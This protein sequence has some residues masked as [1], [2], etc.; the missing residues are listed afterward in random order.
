[1]KILHLDTGRTMRGGQWQAHYLM[2]G[3]RE[4]GHEVYFNAPHGVFDIVHAHDAKA[5]RNAVLRGLKPLVVSRRVAF[6]IQRGPFSR[7][8]Y[9]HGHFIAIS[10]FVKG[11]LLEAGIDES[12]IDV[13]HDGVPRLERAQPTDRVVVLDKRKPGSF[14][15]ERELP[16]ARAF[17]YL[18]E[19]E[20]LGSA[21][22]LAM[23]AGVPV[24]A[25]R[26]GGIPEAVE[27]G[28]TG[29]LVEDQWEPALSRITPEMSVQALARYER[30]FTVDRMVEATIAVY[31]KVL[32]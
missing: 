22:L 26:T 27:D 9:N 20:G 18:S 29:I 1:M 14:D 5:H 11:R 15:A 12:R 16:G 3:L 31:N 17:V 21:I 19:E 4:R 7:W 8:K 28:V 24:I 2:R 25:S 30:L 6:P 10:R 32:G 23:S 13:V